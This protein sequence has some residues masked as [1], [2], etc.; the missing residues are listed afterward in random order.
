L[1]LLIIDQDDVALNLAWRAVQA[2]HQV[3][4]F[5]DP[6]HAKHRTGEGFNAIT[7]VDNW[8]PLASWADVVFP[9]SNGKYIERLDVLRRQ[10]VKVFG[11]STRSAALEIRRSEGMQFLE[12]HGIEVPPY[13]VFNSL[14]EAEAYVWKTEARF[15]FKTMGDNEDKSLSYCSRSPA[16]MIARLDRWQA[17]GLNPKGPVML[18]QFIEGIEFGVSCWLGAEGRIG[19][20]NEN[21]E[22]KRLM[23]AEGGKGCGPN[24]GE[25][26][27]VL[28][29]VTHSKLG[30]Q[31]LAP[32]IDDLVAMGHRGDVDL[33][34]IIDAAGKPWPLEFT[35]RAG[36]PAFNI[37]M[38]AHKGDPL[39]WM[40][41]AL[42]G[43]VDTLTV[44]TDVAVGIVIAQPDFPYDQKPPEETGGI[45]IYGLDKGN[46]RYIAPQGVRMQRM[47]VMRDS[48]LT[49]EPIWCTSSTYVAVVTGLGAS[50]SQACE[51][52]YKVIEQIHLANIIYRDDIG[53]GMEAC[54]PE[55][56]AHGYAM[57]M[58]YA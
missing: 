8:I 13:K 24:T 6:K 40:L 54:L 4:L 19:P 50:V 33:N 39:K 1:K 18:Q 52:A 47:P 38:A 23:S 56:H 44:S 34:C 32:L 36:W 58:N 26:G 42:E 22:H 10:G 37:Q 17:L 29:Y 57:E 41:D 14:A 25:M 43:G 31:V 46:L 11:P 7:R 49:E 3:R 9:V 15:V 16:D 20:W 48:I 53:E 55:L 21:F 51:R 35:A 30:E 2:G 12:R 5:I 28:Q 27:S 45:P